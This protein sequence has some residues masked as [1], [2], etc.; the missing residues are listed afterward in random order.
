MNKAR[1][2]AFF[3]AANVSWGMRPGL[4]GRSDDWLFDDRID[5][6]YQVDNSFYSHNRNK[7][8]RGH[9]TRRED[10]EYGAKPEDA[11]RRAN[12]TC[13]WTN[14]TPQ[15]SIFNQDK[16]PDKTVHLWHGLER[17]ILEETAVANKFD[18]QVFTGPIFGA[19]D[20][21]YQAIQYPLDYWK[22]VVAVAEKPNRLDPDKPIRTLFA[23]GYV[24]GQKDVIDQFGIEAAREVPFGDYAMYQRP[25]RLIE[26]LTG[27][28]FTYGKNKQ[29]SDLDPLDKPS[30]RP[31]RRT[32]T[33]EAFGSGTGDALESFSDIVLD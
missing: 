19:A 6:K 10:M 12:G 32:R 30:W 3:S 28:K 14:C 33:D 11:V 25:I 26:D 23:T 20:P 9:L 29:L 22:I 15:H 8:D 27:L 13:T 16:H 4:S 5:R 21:E 2:F 1:R 24:L 17:Y 18:V 31:R 7:F